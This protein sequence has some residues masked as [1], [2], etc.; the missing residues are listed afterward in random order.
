MKFS[1][2]INVICDH[3]EK[4]E[5]LA[6]VGCDHGFMSFEVIRRGLS[7]KVYV[8]DISA[9]SLK[10][11]QLLLND[12][13]EKGIVEAVVTDGLDGVPKVDEAV[14]CG[15]GGKE[16][17]GILDRS[18]NV[19]RFLVLNP[20]KNAELVRKWLIEK[21]FGIL[22]D[23]MFFDGEK[24]YELIVA[25]KDFKMKDYSVDEINYG[26]DNFHNNEDFLRFINKKLDKFN[27][28]KTNS[29]LEKKICELKR[30]RNEIQ[31]N[32]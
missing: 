16:I 8:T 19:P 3:I 2:R 22:K 14:I 10:K 28:G 7:Q 17:I 23:F 11:A 12:Y 31:R 32:F 20:M 6:D 1:K 15:M 21:S 9:P 25:Q 18:V 13:I 4:V 26:R 24:F 30:I 5:S 27:V 29:Q